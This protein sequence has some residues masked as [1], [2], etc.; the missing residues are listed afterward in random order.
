MMEVLAR[1][2]EECW[3]PRS[4]YRRGHV[5]LALI[6]I[7]SGQPL[8][9]RLL[10]KTIGISEWQARILLD[11]MRSHGY[12]EVDPVGGCTLTAKGAEA[13]REWTSIIKNVG[14]G[15]PCSLR[16]GKAGAYAV[17]SK[18]AAKEAAAKPM[19][20]RDEIVRTGARA[21]LILV[22][23][24]EGFEAPPCSIKVECNV[25]AEEGEGVVVAYAEDEAGALL[26]LVEGLLSFYSRS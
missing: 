5:V 10:A 24:E 18:N 12:I 15:L 2:V 14:T 21:A 19:D 8:G 25:E 3:T 6:A 20:L 23:R 11:K 16:L 22:K 1:A 13:A 9:R 7:A 26:A 4:R 17:I